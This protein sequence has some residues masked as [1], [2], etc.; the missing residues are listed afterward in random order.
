MFQP[1]TMVYSIVSVTPTADPQS[2]SAHISNIETRTAINYIIAP[3]E[4]QA[5]VWG[6]QWVCLGFLLK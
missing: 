6:Q 5:F 4:Y 1:Q 3:D 2:S